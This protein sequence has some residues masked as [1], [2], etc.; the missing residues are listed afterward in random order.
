MSSDLQISDQLAIL[1]QCEVELRDMLLALGTHNQAEDSHPI[2]L[3]KIKALEESDAMYTRAQ[4]YE[5]IQN[6]MELHTKKDFNV[7]HTGY[8]EKAKELQLKLDKLEA[9]INT[10]N[11]RLNLHTSQI[12]GYNATLESI[13]QKIEDKYAPILTN[14][15]TAYQEAE[16]QNN[17]VLAQSYMD[18]ISTTLEEKRQ[19]LLKALNDW[20]IA[21][22]R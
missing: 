12:D 4:I 10:L 6:Q 17:S 11:T 2:I 18:S 14:L 16:R 1:Q 22:K 3:R 20:A 9:D 13:M 8:E 5:M 19:E 15:S 21:N 7:A